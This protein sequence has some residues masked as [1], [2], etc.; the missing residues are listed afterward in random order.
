MRPAIET[1]LSLFR[2]C[3][4]ECEE[5]GEYY[6]DNWNNCVD[7]WAICQRRDLQ[8]LG[9]ITNNR[10]E[11]FYLAVKASLR[12][13][14]KS[15]SRHHLAESMEIVLKLVSTTNHS[16]KFM[17]SLLL[18]K[19]FELA[20]SE[21]YETE[22]LE[23][24]EPMDIQVRHVRTQRLYAVTGHADVGFSCDCYIS[25]SFGIACRHII[26]ARRSLNARPFD[27]KDFLPRWM[28]TNAGNET[29]NDLLVSD[30]Q[31][32]DAEEG[33]MDEDMEDYVTDIGET[34][35]RKT[36]AEPR[37]L[38]SA[39]VRFKGAA[40]LFT[41]FSSLL[42]TFPAAR[43]LGATKQ[44]GV[45]F[46]LLDQGH[47]IVMKQGPGDVVA[48]NVGVQ[49]CLDK[50]QGFVGPVSPLPTSNEE[51]V[52]VDET[53]MDQNVT[54]FSILATGRERGRPRLAQKGQTFYNNVTSQQTTPDG[55]DIAS[56]I[57][58]IS[59]S[60]SCG[61]GTR[62]G[63]G[64]KAVKPAGG[65]LQWRPRS[66]SPQDDFWMTVATVRNNM[67]AEIR[68]TKYD[69]R[70]LSDI[71]TFLSV[72]A[73]QVFMHYLWTASKGTICGLEDP[74]L[75]TQCRDDGVEINN[76]RASLK[77]KSVVLQIL[78]D[79]VNHFLTLHVDKSGIATVYDF[80]GKTPS[81]NV[82]EQLRLIL[83]NG[84]N[85]LMPSIR[86]KR[87]VPTTVS[88]KRLQ[89]PPISPTES[90]DTRPQNTTT[91]QL[92]EWQRKI[93]IGGTLILLLLENFLFHYSAF[94]YVKSAQ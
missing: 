74:A 76:I 86:L 43:Y 61:D 44:L 83:G 53:E 80:V 82:V 84:Y 81:A 41:E 57:S 47:T 21:R 58:K 77:R 37:R 32:E 66:V 69:E 46:S 24:V 91:V 28:R 9:N 87:W 7:R 31:I 56:Q 55:V 35:T 67:P 36:Q 64:Q 75:L 16:T 29:L 90:A 65:M 94:M 45:A 63:P 59:K 2:N 26:S 13:G 48:R 62:G 27:L 92:A 38:R 8:T 17:E 11:R 70:S 33:V 23:A 88:A 19:Q 50:D 22:I 39:T 78:F 60:L 6:T 68:L 10:V 85:V 54:P 93:I 15:S 79:G 1:L 5:F 52:D 71:G 4:E 42:S 30:E 3:D 40:E 20:R 49:V 18:K 89:M 25:C 51:P 72:E 34:A 14:G 12:A 73:A